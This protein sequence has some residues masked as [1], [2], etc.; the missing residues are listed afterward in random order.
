MMPTLGTI[1]EALQS[2]TDARLAGNVGAAALPITGLASLAEA[3]HT[4]LSFLSS[5]RFAPLLTSTRAAC[6]IVGPGFE[7][8]ASQRA[9]CIVSSD[10]YY[11]FALAT[12]WWKAQSIPSARASHHP[13]AYIDPLAQIDDGVSI[14]AF[15]VVG[16]HARI[17]S[18]AQLG[19]HCVI[20]SHASVGRGSSLAA[21]VSLGEGCSLGEHCVVHPGVVIGADGFGFAPHE[22]RWEKIEQLGSVRIGNNVEL[23][24]N[25]CIDRGALSDT[26]VG[27]GV[28]IDNLVQVGH[29]VHIGPHTAIAGCAGIAGSARIGAHC[30]IGG[31]AVV[32]GHLVLADHVHI[33][34]SSVV[35]RSLA[36]AGNYTG[37][38]PIDDNA[39][40]EKN[41]ASLKQLNALRERV[42]SLERRIAGLAPGAGTPS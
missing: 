37:F 34:A 25:T 30:T 11:C 1:V 39:A 13:T 29:N 4:E 24:A 26:T 21:H 31:G 8:A 12:Q 15:A 27:D 32:L 22:G 9:A 20:G 38:F 16:P 2:R 3:K 28:K 41:A 33:S 23:G 7:A 36:H 10:P 6:V 5:A 19:A 42:K 40:W 14:G 17:A 18:G 35:T